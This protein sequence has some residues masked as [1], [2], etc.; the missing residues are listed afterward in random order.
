MLSILMLSISI[1]ND[2][3]VNFVILTAFHHAKHR[4]SDCRYAECRGAQKVY[5][6]HKHDVIDRGPMEQRI[7]V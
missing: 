5:K 7:F 2:I 6:R 3:R 4:F 1:L